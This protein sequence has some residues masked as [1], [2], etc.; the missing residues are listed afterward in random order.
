M[1]L[2][3]PHSMN[4]HG[5]ARQKCACNGPTYPSYVFKQ[6]DFI[7]KFNP[8]NLMMTM[9]LNYY[10]YNGSVLFNTPIYFIS[11]SIG[12][13]KRKMRILSA[14]KMEQKSFDF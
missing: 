5:L 12:R 8:S 7:E 14:K 1:Q 13:W 6:R 4:A 10:D 3:V 9:K 2:L 11:H